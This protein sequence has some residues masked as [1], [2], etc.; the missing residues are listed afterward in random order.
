MGTEKRLPDNRLAILGSWLYIPPP[1]PQPQEMDGL[2][3]P[4]VNDL[5][6]F[7]Q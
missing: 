5:Q 1:A 4:K 3:V 6:L 2:S 7:M